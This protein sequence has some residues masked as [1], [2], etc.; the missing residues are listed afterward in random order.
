M[1]TV[2]EL[3]EHVGAGPTDD[4]LERLLEAATQA[5]DLRFGPEPAY[6]EETSERVPPYRSLVYLSRRAQSV[7]D[8]QEDGASLDAAAYELQQSGRAL[9]RL[10]ADGEPIFWGARVDVTY[11][12]YPDGAERD[13][14]C[15]Q[16]VNLELDYAPGLTGSTV[17]PWT[18]QH[19]A[20][21]ESYRKMRESILR[22]YRPSV[23][24]VW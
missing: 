4:V 17:G 3:R 19:P 5:L 18:E 23:V 14:V 22:S 10:D 2:E 15:I 13:R 12:P 1:L 11:A 6:D 9:R 20:G 21:D 16:L 8:V 7:S 24:G